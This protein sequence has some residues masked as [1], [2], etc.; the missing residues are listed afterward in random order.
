MNEKNLSITSGAIF[1]KAYSIDNYLIEY[2]INQSDICA[3]YVSSSGIYYPNNEKELEQRVLKDNYYE[4]Y[5]KRFE[6]AYKHIFIRD[7]AKQF[8]INGINEKLCTVDSI[9]DFLRKETDKYKIY[10]IGSSAGGYLATLLGGVLCAEKIFVFSGY[11]DLNI[12]DKEIWYYIERYAKDKVKSKWYS[13]VNILDEYQ[14]KML[15]FYPMQ[16]L[17]DVLQS[18]RIIENPHIM[19]IPVNSNVHGV[20]ISSA[21]LYAVMNK[22]ID[23]NLIIQI[24]GKTSKQ[25]NIIYFGIFKSLC[26]GIEEKWNHIF[27]LLNKIIKKIRG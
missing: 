18:E 20:P 23:D 25:I 16:L 26:I 27:R 9:I 4:W 24:R 8:Y 6:E 1:E 22:P 10:V 13:I 5:T 7:V 17:G 12:V 15:Y 19:K 14:G 2:S 3:I 21:F 11:F